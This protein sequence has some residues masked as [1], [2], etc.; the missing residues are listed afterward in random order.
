MLFLFKHGAETGNYKDILQIDD[1][2][3]PSKHTRMDSESLRRKICYQTKRR[4]STTITLD[5]D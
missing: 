3:S 5:I 2:P 1:Q 4:R